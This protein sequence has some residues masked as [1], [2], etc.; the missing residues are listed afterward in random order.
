MAPAGDTLSWRET[1]GSSSPAVV[2]IHG[3]CQ[4]GRS[5][6]VVSSRLASSWRVLVP[7]LPGHG[8]SPLPRPYSL[9]AVR[10]ALERDLA[11]RGAREVA[12]V[13]CSIG[14]YHALGL[15]LAGR[16]RVS[17]MALLSPI[18]GADPEV[19][20]AYAGFAR[21]FAAGLD[22]VEPI[23]SLIVPAGWAEAYPGEAASLKARVAETPLP[24][25]V[26]EC[27]AIGRMADLRPRLPEI[28]VPTLVRVGAADRSTPPAWAEA[29]ARAIPGAALEVVPGVGHLQLEQDAEA[30]VSALV[31]FLS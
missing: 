20:A 12:V 18:A 27:E 6:D 17:R 15:A 21:S 11:A 5:F 7:D 3:Q 29:V 4:D 9:E 1:G 26:A 19:K 30:A 23:V 24:A 28:R 31:R 22:F 16:I 14:C 25:L 13:G 2:C 8:R 10:S